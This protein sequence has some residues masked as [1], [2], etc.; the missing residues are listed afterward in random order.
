MHKLILSFPDLPEMPKVRFIRSSSSTL[1]PQTLQLLESRFQTTVLEAYAMTEASH[2]VTSNLLPPNKRKAGTVGLPR[3]VEVRI[4]DSQDIDIPQGEE[5]EICIRGNSI[6]P[7]YLNNPVANEK[8][9]TADGFFRTGD[10]GKVDNEGYLTITGR[11]KELINKGGENISPV[12]LDNLISS[13]PD[14]ADVVVFAVDDEMYGQE[15]AA[16]LILSQGAELKAREL[17]KWIGER[18]A[19]YKVP[20]KVSDLSADTKRG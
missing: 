14:V 13:H 11:I 2:Q 19:A 12:E 1:S 15:P 5:G 9:F 17:K 7:G 18:V 3:G 8:S 6:T 4:L 16:A 20:K 10:Q